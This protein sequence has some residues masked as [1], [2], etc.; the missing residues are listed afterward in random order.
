MSS[1]PTKMSPSELIAQLRGVAI[2]APLPASLRSAE[3]KTADGRQ[4]A[5]SAPTEQGLARLKSLLTPAAKPTAP[6]RPPEQA[7]KTTPMGDIKL[8]P[9]QAAPAH[10]P[11]IFD[12]AE[13]LPDDIMILNKG[14][15]EIRGASH[16]EPLFH[17]R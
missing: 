4:A 8:P 13:P 9:P 17:I 7:T 1:V 6:T 5:T 12:G 11:P 3:V 10:A 2:G 14:T 15:G 16:L